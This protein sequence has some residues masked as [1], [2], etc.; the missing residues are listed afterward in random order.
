MISKLISLHRLIVG[1]SLGALWGCS[2]STAAEKPVALSLSRAASSPPVVAGAL[3]FTFTSSEPVK[4]VPQVDYVVRNVSADTLVYEISGCTTDLRLYD[5]GVARTRVYSQVALN[6]PCT[7]QRLRYT[8]GPGGE[9]TSTLVLISP[10][11]LEIVFK[12]TYRFAVTV[13][14][15][16][17]EIEVSVGEVT[18]Q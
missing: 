15:V 5:Q 11:A 12:G 7:G 9:A 13:P 14:N 3:Q 10:L 17:P 16:S 1:L 18:A 8:L 4:G 2:S 6:L